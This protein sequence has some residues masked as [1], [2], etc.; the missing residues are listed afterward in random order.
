MKADV[1]AEACKKAMDMV[2]FL[3]EPGYRAGAFHVAL[4][5][6]IR[7]SEAV[8]VSRSAEGA[9]VRQKRNGVQ[10]RSESQRRI[11]ELREE[12]YFDE[13]RL[14]AD[15]RTKLRLQGYHHNPNDVGMALLRLAQKKLLRRLHENGNI[16]RYS[17]P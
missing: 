15:V 5:R 1:F 9:E 6:L 14:P 17:R 7:E 11:L 12:G 8:A 13:P 16:Y 4:E 10:V 3:K 2:S